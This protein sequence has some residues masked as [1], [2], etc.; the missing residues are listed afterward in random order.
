MT[1]ASSAGAGREWPRP[2]AQQGAAEGVLVHDGADQQAHL[3]APVAEVGVAHHLVAA[4]A[5]QALDRLA[6]DRGA[7]VAHVHRLGDVGAAVVD[8]HPAGTAPAARRPARGSA[9]ISLARVDRASLGDAHVDEAEAGDLD[10]GQARVGRSGRRPP[11]AAISRGLLLGRS[12]RRPGRRCD[13]KSARS[14]RSDAVTRPRSGGES[15]G[16]EGGRDRLAQ[17]PFQIAHGVGVVP[18]AAPAR[19]GRR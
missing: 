5:V 1:L 8:H 4:E 17:G 6:D 7:Q 14:G 16:G 2:D 11:A 12:W 18:A 3:E 9:A 15:T 10:G 19:P 13:W